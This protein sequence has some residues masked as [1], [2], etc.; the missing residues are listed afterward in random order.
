ME[1]LQIVGFGLIATVLLVIL[2]KQRPEM[3]VQLSIAAGVILFLFILT[4]VTAVVQ[5]LDDLAN[6]AQINRYY[7]TTLLK[8]VG[9]AYVAEF[10]A[11]ICRDAGEG[12]IASKVELGAK[13]LVLVLALPIVLALMES[14]IN[15]LPGGASP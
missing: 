13:V 4:K 9:I 15:L 8:I 2:R 10:G 14:L 11:Q 7:L 12:A 5:V 6:R 3:A 1:V